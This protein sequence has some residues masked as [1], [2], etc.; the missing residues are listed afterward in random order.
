MAQWL[1]NPTSIHEDLSSISGLAPWLRIWC[2]HELWYRS[3]MRLRSCVAVVWSRPAATAL[4]L[5]L[6][7]EP[8]YAT[9]VALKRQKKRRK[10]KKKKGMQCME[11]LLWLSG[12]RT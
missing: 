8:L 6:A 7:W 11:V 5:L 4:I 1:T 10:K 3:K 2:C 12:V 9:G